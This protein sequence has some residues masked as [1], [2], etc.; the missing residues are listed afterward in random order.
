MA[1]DEWGRR[2]RGLRESAQRH[3]SAGGGADVD[4][5]QRLGPLLKVRLHFQNDAIL[6]QL[7]EDRGH[8]PLAKRV[9]EGVID[10]LRG[11]A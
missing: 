8:H 7:R 11:D 5:L 3:L 9:V 2:L 4:V 1:D 10:H 6:V